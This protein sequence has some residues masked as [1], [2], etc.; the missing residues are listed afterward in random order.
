MKSKRVQGK[1]KSVP[2]K[3]QSFL[4]NNIQALKNV[5]RR[6]KRGF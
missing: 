1:K 6:V 2:K 3:G 5:A 4:G